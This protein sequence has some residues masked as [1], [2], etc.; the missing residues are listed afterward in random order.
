M[1]GKY[2]K[3]VKTAVKLIWSSF[4]RDEIRRGYAMLMQAAQQGDADALAFIARCFMGEEYV[5]PQAGFKADDE[6]ASK[7]MQKSAM[8]GSATG[9][10]CAARSANLTP[11]VERAMPFASFKEAFE[12][13]LGQAERGD[14]FCCYM[15]GNVYYWG[16]YLRVEPDYAKQFKDENGY[17]A[18]AYPIA[19]EWYERSFDGGLCAGWG[20]YCNIRESG[21]CDIAQDVFEKYYL[22]LADISPVIC[23]NYGYY[24]RT[25]KGDS[26][27][28]LLRY[29]EA[30]RR[31]DPQAAY[32]AGHIYEAG[33]EVDENIDLAYQLYEM[34]AKCGHPAGQFEVGY[35]LFEGFGDVEQDYAKAVE[36]FEKAYW[37]PKCSEVTKAQCAAYLGICYQEGLGTVQDDDVAF[38]YLHEAGEGVDHLWDS[39]TVRLLTA[40]GV[41]YAFGRG[42]EADIELGYQYFEDAVKLGSEE[43]KKYIGYINSPDYEADE[44]KKEEPATPVAPFWQNV[45]AMIR[46]AVAAD[47]REILGRI[48]DE[49]IY[50]VALVTDR[51][52]CSL[53]LAVNTLEYLESEDEEPDDECKWHPDEWGYSDGHGS[54]LVKLSKSLWENHATLP[55]EAFFFSAMISAMAQVKG[56]GIFGERTEEITFFI[57]ISDDEDAENLEDSS[58]MTLNSPELAAAFLNRNK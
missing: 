19:K 35:Y 13:I 48:D 14:A 51:Y 15:V 1:K 56:S 54:E 52:C 21:L 57:S 40:L 45:A 46:D 6:N 31:G 44:R 42:T 26:Y 17:N 22:K 8:M 38:D 20:N 3:Q 4:D 29:V 47:L 53:F 43:A 24:L 36:W 49:R 58:A 10:L 25:E 30:A 11:S 39:I 28:G 12:E 7:L 32:N 18:W 5:W 2:S 27:G 55:G 50:T 16:D 37:N 33:E 34:A 23:N 9:V 41:A